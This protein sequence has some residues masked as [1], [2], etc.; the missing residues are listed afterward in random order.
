MCMCVCVSAY[1]SITLYI[2]LNVGLIAGIVKK[3]LS[4]LILSLYLRLISKEKLAWSN[5]W[6]VNREA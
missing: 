4:S 5:F 2:A 1:K 6:V 3:I